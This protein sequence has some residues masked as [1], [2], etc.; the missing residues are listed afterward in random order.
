MVRGEPLPPDWVGKPWALHQG[1]KAARGQWLL[2][3]DADSRH[4]PLGVASALAF[5]L[6]AG[7]DALTVATHQEL[8]TFWEKAILPAVLGMIM[9]ATGPVDA[10]NDPMRPERA[11]ANGQ[12]I[13]VRRQAFEALGGHAGLRD[14]ILEDVEFARLVKEDGRFRLI[15]AGGADLATVRMYHSLGEIWSGFTK[16]M[17]LGARTPAEYYAGLAA[18]GLISFVPPLLA[19]AHLRSGR[20][21]AALEAAAC[22]FAAIAAAARG[23]RRTG[24]PASLALLN[25]LGLSMLVVIGLNSGVRWHSGRGVEWRGRV[26]GK[27]KNGDGMP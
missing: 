9:I 6:D 1:A 5:A 13:L 12:Y 25:P 11:V 7:A 20:R 18:L 24:H 4:A 10:I 17:A 21:A 27:R 26:Y 3:T 23:F 22:S 15:L 19:I 16:N 2:F 8:R 14:K